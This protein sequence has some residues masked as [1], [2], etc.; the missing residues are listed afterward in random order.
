[1]KTKTLYLLILCILAASC[2]IN[3]FKNNLRHGRWIY[4]DSTSDQV[5]VSKGRYRKGSETGTW[6][7]YSNGQLFRLE[8]FRGNKAEVVNY[9]PNKLIESR[10]STGLDRSAAM[11]HWYYDGKWEFYTE[12]GELDSVKVYDKGELKSAEAVN[13]S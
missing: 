11:I 10:G 4:Q 7:H 1:M 13:R 12:D 3:R 2:R 5:L 8:K 9:Y 6:K